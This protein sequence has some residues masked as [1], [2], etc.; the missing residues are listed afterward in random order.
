M[1][2][3]RE[4]QIV[5]KARELGKSDD[6]IKQ[7]IIR[8]RERRAASQPQYQPEPEVGLGQSLVRGVTSPFL[9]LFESGKDIVKGAGYTA[10]SL[11]S[12]A[13]GE[14]KQA[15]LML[16]KAQAE[17]ENAGD[18]GYFGKVQGLK[19]MKDA[20]GT[21]LEIGSYAIGAP[22]VKN[23]FAQGAKAIMPNI[24]KLAGYGAKTGAVSGLGIGLQQEDATLGSV[25]KT[26]AGGALIGG[27]A[28]PV[29]SAV[30]T[31]LTKGAYATGLPQKIMSKTQAGKKFIGGVVDEARTRVAKAYEKSLP[32]SQPQIKKE[33]LKLSRTGDNLFTTLAKYN[34]D[35]SD[36]KNSVDDLNSLSDLFSA[37]SARAVVDDPT[38][39][40]LTK[41]LDKAY[42]GIDDRIKSA[43][44]RT[45]AKEKVTNEIMS[46]ISENKDKIILDKD[47]SPQLNAQLMSR[48]R[49]IGNELTPFNASDPQKIGRS[50]GYS[51]SDAI[52]DVV[53]EDGPFEAYRELNRQWGQV[54][55]AKEMLEDFALKGK[56]FKTIGGMTGT[57][58]RRLLSAGYGFSRGGLGGAVMSSIGSETAADL[59]SNPGFRSFWDKKLIEY[60]GKKVTP[61][62]VDRLTK[63]IEEFV[64]SRASSLRLPSPGQTVGR[65]NLPGSGILSGQAK[66]R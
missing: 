1:D 51:L 55:N 26:T 35:V 64:A 39:Y 42:A 48:L 63:E 6:F 58:A 19:G 10:A 60:A 41:V 13:A 31:G 38:Q 65:I 54:L 17:R 21:G 36:L 14:D 5:I 28:A 30:T 34:V 2:R 7:A 27:I 47:G 16:Q 40:N 45:S 11:V 46:L 25:A 4:R 57:L 3:E 66:L 59:L 22:G 52:R 20:V 32:L 29:L 12:K 56:K 15:D 23:I 61:E 44:A 8:D 53:E 9:K 37:P 43:T 50:A 33:A 62:I 49:Q 24:L 18:Y